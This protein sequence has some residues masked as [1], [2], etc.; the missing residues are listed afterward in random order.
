MPT[1][2]LVHPHQVLPESL[3]AA[4][5]DSAAATADAMQRG[6]SRC[7]ASLGRGAGRRGG[8]EARGERGRGLEG[9]VGFY[10]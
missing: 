2:P 10:G 4:I 1:P 3:A 8:G 7:T 5:M 9:G 6:N